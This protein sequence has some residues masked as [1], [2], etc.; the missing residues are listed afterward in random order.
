MV[1]ALVSWLLA[2]ARFRVAQ[3]AAAHAAAQASLPLQVELSSAK[4]RA[5]RVPDL[6]SRLSGATQALNQ[7]NE[8]KAALQT[9]VSRLPELE[10][11]RS[12]AVRRV[13]SPP[14]RLQS[15]RQTPRR[16]SFRQSRA[17]R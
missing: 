9:E 2:S 14:A 5:S 10:A 1:G 7:A 4:E 15:S 11:R 6:E 16:V 12:H 8:R 17:A 13:M 3:S